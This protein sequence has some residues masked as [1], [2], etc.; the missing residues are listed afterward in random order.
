MSTIVKK[1]KPKF[2]VPNLGAKHRKHVKDRW[3]AQRG[4]D[5]KQ[6]IGKK[7]HGNSPKIGYKNSAVARFRNSKGLLE[8][9]VHNEKEL[10]EQANRQ[11]VA[12]RLYHALSRRKKEALEQIAKEH[13]I[14]LA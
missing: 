2:A 8:V 11:D 3:R 9:L 10:L 4:D 14:K 1:K 7:Y 6:R 12:V 13:N 5:N